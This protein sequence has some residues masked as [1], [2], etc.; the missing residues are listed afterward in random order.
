MGARVLRGACD[1]VLSQEGE[2]ERKAGK[3][4]LYLSAERIATYALVWAVD[5]SKRPIVR[6]RPMVP[7]SSTQR[8]SRLSSGLVVGKAVGLWRSSAFAIGRAKRTIGKLR[9]KHCGQ[10]LIIPAAKARLVN[11]G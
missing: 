11:V 10:F 9:R 3:A 2:L 6:Y 7:W 1:S 5:N 4:Y 8:M